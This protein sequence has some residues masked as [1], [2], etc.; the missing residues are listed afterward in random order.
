MVE[1]SFVIFDPPFVGATQP[2]NLS[3]G[4]GDDTEVVYYNI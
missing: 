2:F 4:T 3:V 1:L